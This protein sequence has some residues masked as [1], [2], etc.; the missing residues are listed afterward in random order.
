MVVATRTLTMAQAIAEAIG[1][2]MERD[3]RVFVLGEDVGIY[4]G[5]FGATSG[6]LQRFG[7]ERIMDTPISE[8]AFIGAA[9][10]AA[11][12]GMRPIVELMFVD[13]FGVC[14][15]QIYN[16]L[17]KNTYMSG[18]NVHLP[19]VLTTAIGGGYNDAAQHSQCLY[20]IFAHIPGLKVVVPSNAYDAKGLM[21]QAIR[22]DNPVMYLFHKGI[23]GLP[24]M[25][26]FVGST[27]EVPE[28]SY[29][30][31]FGQARIVREGTDLTI[32]TLSQMV[33]KAAAAA[34]AAE[35][36]GVSVEVLDLRTLVPLDR[37]AVLR[38]V[39]KTGR[40]L[41]ADEDYLQFGVSGEIAALVAEQI[42]SI[43]MKAPVK[44]LGV[45]NVPIP[46]SRPLEEAVIPQV[47]HI[48][49]AIRQLMA[50]PNR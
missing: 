30:V 32:V 38:S 39:A 25:A 15:D 18:G 10:G 43:S 4:G 16:H 40:L 19:V 48:T 22:D 34:E 13:F 37:E 26:Y 7:P 45:P 28:D 12:A 2:E 44:R 1:Q 3:Q 8:T 11:A 50:T 33:H 24:W 49:T 5:I 42:G 29:T 21:I 36:D 41:I 47:S 35:N 6:L 17:A 14:M 20:G 23:M 27:T 9:T 31:P 46:Y